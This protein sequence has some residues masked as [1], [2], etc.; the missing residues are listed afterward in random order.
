MEISYWDCEFCDVDETWD[1]EEETVIFGCSH[2]KSDGHCGLNNKVCG[3][4]KDC[5]LL[6]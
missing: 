6:D 2:P 1:G 5:S 3:E 4:E